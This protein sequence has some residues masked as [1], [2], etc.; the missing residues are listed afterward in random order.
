MEDNSI[1][2][3]ELLLMEDGGVKQI[4]HIERLNMLLG[5][6]YADRI[7]A[8]IEA[9]SDVIADKVSM[10]YDLPNEEGE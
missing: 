2:L 6:E 8:T 4:I 7:I 10:T 3:I 1:Q 9:V 5:E